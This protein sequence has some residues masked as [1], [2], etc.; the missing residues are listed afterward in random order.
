[1]AGKDEVRSNLDGMDTLDSQD[2]NNAD[3]NG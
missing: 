3:W 1:M 2:W